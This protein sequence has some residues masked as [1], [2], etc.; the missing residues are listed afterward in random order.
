LLL[1]EVALEDAR[2][3]KSTVRLKR[4]SAGNYGY[5]YTADQDKIAEAE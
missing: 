5:V 4:D 2:N 3:A 1:A